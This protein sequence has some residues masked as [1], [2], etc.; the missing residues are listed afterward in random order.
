MVRPAIAH[1]YATAHQPNLVTR[2]TRL[3]IRALG[4]RSGLLSRLT[5]F[6]LHL[7]AVPPAFHLHCVKKWSKAGATKR[8][9][10]QLRQFRV[11][12]WCLFEMIFKI[13][14]S[15][16]NLVDRVVPIRDDFC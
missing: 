8:Q 6:H 15:L 9:S 3:I 10:S 12:D 2:K 11:T 14:M 13:K 7:F 1:P 16:D 5:L 4:L